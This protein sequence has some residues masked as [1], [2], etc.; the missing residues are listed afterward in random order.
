MINRSD[1]P[2]RSLRAFG[3]ALV[4]SLAL[5]G[6]A[7][8]SASALSMS[9]ST[10]TLIGGNQ[11]AVFRS[12]ES[13]TYECERSE[14]YLKG[15]EATGGTVESFKLRGCKTTI[16]GGAAY[17]T[18]AGQP[19]GT[20]AA[21]NLSYRLVYLDAAKTKFGIKLAPPPPAQWFEP[22]NPFTEFTCGGVYKWK[23]TG[24]VIGQITSPGLNVLAKSVNLQFAAS[25]ST[26]NYQQ[27]E[28]AGTY[29]LWASLNGGTATALGLTTNMPLVAA[30]AV[31][32]L[33]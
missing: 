19:T 9:P 16:F 17:C 28:G 26:Q 8:G 30:E 15:V 11:A 31:K 7:A 5:A 10:G 27:V 20:I 23:W 22:G 3:L 2:R 13:P 25:G 14:T 32:F 1:S 6:L 21:S 18:T 24:S 4:A 33:P 12:A 29:H